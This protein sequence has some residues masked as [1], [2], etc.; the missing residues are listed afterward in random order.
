MPLGTW[1]VNVLGGLFIGVVA[2]LAAGKPAI[3]SADAR[4]LL[5]VGFCGAFTTFSTFGLETLTLVQAGRWGQAVAYVLATNAFVLLS[6]GIGLW[7][8]RWIHPAP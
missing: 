4:L 2:A 8:G 7:L 6:T 1:S 5:A 3:L